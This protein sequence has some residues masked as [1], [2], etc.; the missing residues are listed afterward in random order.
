[1]MVGMYVGA[2]LLAWPFV[3]TGMM[4]MMKQSSRREVAWRAL[5]VTALSM[6]AVSLGM[7]AMTWWMMMVR[8]TM[9]MPHEDEI[10]WF[11]TL[12]LASTIGFY[13]AWPLNWPMV[14]TK[15]K[16]GVM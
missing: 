14:R 12:W 11:I 3:Q 13:V 2:V 16:Q 1:M 6:A 9:M 4:A 10:L 15:L 7:M 5:G 8:R